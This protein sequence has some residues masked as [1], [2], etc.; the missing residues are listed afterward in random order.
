M[1]A[2]PN[3][4]TGASRRR[5]QLPIEQSPREMPRR[6][7]RLRIERLRHIDAAIVDDLPRDPQVEGVGC[8]YARNLAA[9]ADMRGNPLFIRDAELLRGRR[10]DQDDRAIAHVRAVA[11]VPDVVADRVQKLRFGGGWEGLRI[12]D[13]RRAGCCGHRRAD[14]WLTAGSGEVS[15]ACCSAP[16]AA[17]DTAATTR[18]TPM[19][20][21][22][23]EP[24]ARRRSAPSGGRPAPQAKRRTGDPLRCRV[25][26]RD[27]LVGAER[28]AH[29][30]RD[31]DLALARLAHTRAQ[32]DRGSDEALSSLDRLQR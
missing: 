6:P 24:V 2:S 27:E 30:P 17:N 21:A 8:R 23:S 15:A 28:L 18:A 22:R 12:R 16:D 25:P 4:A 32:V 14:G 9:D 31:E 29:R 13:R 19:R 3:L 7:A 11:V 20:T 26:L 10:V 1:T 5:R